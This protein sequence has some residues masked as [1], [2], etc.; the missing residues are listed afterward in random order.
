MLTRISRTWVRGM[1]RHV[2]LLK[3]VKIVKLESLAIRK[4][5]ATIV[6]VAMIV[7]L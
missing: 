1:L 7:F 4:H 3:I 5:G 6:L 2:N